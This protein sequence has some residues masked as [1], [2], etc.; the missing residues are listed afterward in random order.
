MAAKP[1]PPAALEPDHDHDHDPWETIAALLR[2]EIPERM[3][4]MEHFWPH[5]QANAWGAQGLPEDADL[6]GHFD[7]NLKSVL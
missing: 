2:R 6:T 7:L 4:L 1:A 5:I 3:G